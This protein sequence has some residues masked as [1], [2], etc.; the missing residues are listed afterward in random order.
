MNA[1]RLGQ[2]FAGNLE[3]HTR[4][5]AVDLDAIFALRRKFRQLDFQNLFSG[6]RRFFHFRVVTA[7]CKSTF[8]FNRTVCAIDHAKLLTRETF[9]RQSPGRPEPGTGIR[10][11]ARVRNVADL[12]YLYDR[13]RLCG[14]VGK[15]ACRSQINHAPLLHRRHLYKGVMN[16][17]TR[18]DRDSAAA[19]VH[20]AL[21]PVGFRPVGNKTFDGL[22]LISQCRADGL[23]H[24]LVDGKALS[25]QLPIGHLCPFEFRLTRVGEKSRALVIGAVGLNEN[26]FWRKRR[27]LPLHFA[28]NERRQTESGCCNDQFFHIFS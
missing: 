25:R 18:L 14:I 22:D 23:L 21:H 5:D 1:P 9:K 6:R 15:P 12:I 16:D 4:S 20:I 28:V 13:S 27:N 10:V 8:E 7:K 24:I 2:R 26:V 3:R 19:F 11:L 17:F